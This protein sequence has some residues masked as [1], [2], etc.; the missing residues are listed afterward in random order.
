MA[1]VM[2]IHAA[3]CQVT[4]LGTFRGVI[5]GDLAFLVRKTTANAKR[6]A[7]LRSFK[8]PVNTAPFCLEAH[9]RSYWPSPKPSDDNMCGTTA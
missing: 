7:S 1:D 5:I 3:S 9:L 2:K 8:S 6:P 4:S